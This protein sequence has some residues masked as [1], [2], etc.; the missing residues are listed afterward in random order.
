MYRS[1]SLISS[2]FEQYTIKFLFTQLYDPWFIYMFFITSFNSIWVGLMTM[3]HVI[4]AVILGITL[5][6]RLTGFRYNYFRDENTGKFRNPFRGQILKNCFETYG[7]YRLMSL[8]R[9]TR[10]DWSQVYDINQVTGTKI[11]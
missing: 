1:I 7:L 10:V 11:N 4:N 3:F 2:D 5:N 6:E 8:C 9:Y